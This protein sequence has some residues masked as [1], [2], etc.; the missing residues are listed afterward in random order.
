MAK[1]LVPDELW[2]IVEPLIPKHEPSPK[3]GRPPVG[4]RECLTGIVF[5]LKTGIPWEDLPQEMGCGSGM[6]CWRRL[7][8]WQVAGVWDNLVQVLLNELRAA[9]E[10]DFSRAA[11]DSASV[12]AFGGGEK[13]GP[14]PTDRRKPGT[15]HHVLTDA[16]GIP[17]N[18][19]LTA[20][21]QHD[22]T[23]LL[24]LVDSVPPIAGQPGRPR[25]RPD[26]V[27]AD[28][29][30]DSEPHRQELKDRDIE[31]HLAK[32]NTEH[33]SGLGVF[34]WVSERALSWLHGFRRLRTRY[35]RRDDIHEAFVVLA[36]AIICF[37]HLKPELC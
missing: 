13:T 8:D 3:G 6:T 33:G 7:R 22:V 35:D 4:D 25:K 18:V 26:E 36:Q 27:Y 1:P 29:A 16:N 23:Q 31:P 19:T 14:N 24:P 9:D 2:E 34:R 5:V 37:R 11:V 17:L 10:I 28:R 20:A 30:Y 12:R 15:K 21:N 32:R